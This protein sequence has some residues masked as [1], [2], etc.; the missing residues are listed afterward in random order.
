MLPPLPL[1]PESFDPRLLVRLLVMQPTPFCNIRCDYCYLAH[2]D[3]RRFMSAEVVEATLRNLSDCGLLGNDLTVVWHAG[4][5]LVAPR[6]FY[7]AAFEQ[8][9]RFVP[10]EGRISHSIQTNGL[11]LDDDW[12]AL[13]KEHGVQIGVS[14]DGPALLHDRHRRTRDGKGT[15]AR[16]MRGIDSLRRNGV[17]FHVIA[18]VTEDTLEHADA[19]IDFFA[20]EGIT[21]LAFNIDEQEGVNAA[22]SLRA[23]DGEYL[24]FLRRL[25]QSPPVAEGRVR[26]RE[27]A[28]MVQVIK[29]GL[30][31]TKVGVLQFPDNEQVIPFAIT[32]VDHAGNFSC[33]SPELID[34]KHARYGAF[35][36]GNVKHRRML[37]VLGDE[38]FLRIYADILAGVERCR[39]QCVYF[40]LCGGGAPVN[41]LNE[42]GGF[43]TA[44]TN[45]CRKTIQQPLEVALQMMERELELVPASQ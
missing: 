9:A 41:K 14:L 4:E 29:Q 42:N 1:R 18:V 13:F 15:H 23:R 35:T 40:G 36:L 21:E 33:F 31:A 6:T 8:A 26:M 44:E 20:A 39:S 37:D 11:L 12:C 38:I 34:Q 3:E 22:S 17:P 24:E 2:R 25:F 5:P 16:V 28:R 32:T 27:L 45:Y 10:A 7:A 43:D 19:F 30:R